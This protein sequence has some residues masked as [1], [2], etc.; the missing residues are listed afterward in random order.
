NSRR[1]LFEEAAGISKFKSRKKETLKKLEDTDADLARVE[2]ILY[3]IE[4]NLKSL[5]KQDRQTARYFEIKKEY[6]AA[7]IALAKKQ[8]DK[9]SDKILAINLKNEQ[10]NDKKLQLKSRMAKTEA[11]LEKNK[12]KLIHREKL[13][14]SRQ[15]ALNEHVNKIRQF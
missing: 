14:S 2:D 9:H 5:E 6:K 10:E 13:L 4:K 11:L 1:E 3:E 15:K 12:A 8:V 7:S